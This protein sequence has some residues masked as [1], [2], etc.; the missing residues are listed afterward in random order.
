MRI[1][2]NPVPPPP[3]GFGLMPLPIQV[4]VCVCVCVCVQV[5]GR[6]Y[7]LLKFVGRSSRSVH[8]GKGSL[9]AGKVRGCDVLR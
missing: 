7:F 9:Y 4:C 8:A 6:V 5:S 3:L 1:H 2:I